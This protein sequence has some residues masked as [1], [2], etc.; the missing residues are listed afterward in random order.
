MTYD[1]ELVN[2][3]IDN[4]F[5]FNLPDAIYNLDACV[6]D[7]LHVTFKE[8]TGIYVIRNIV[9]GKLYVGSTKNIMK[10]ISEH[11]RLLDE[12]A[13]H[14]SKLQNA[15][16]KYSFK[17]FELRIYPINKD[18]EFLYDIEELLIH[19]YDSYAN[20][21]NMSEDSRCKSS[22]SEEEKLEIGNRMRQCNLG[23][24]CSEEHKRKVGLAKSIQNSG[25]GNPN[26]KLTKQDILFMRSN[27]SAYTCEEFHNMFDISKCTV[28]HIIHLRSWNYPDC[29]PEGYVLPKSMKK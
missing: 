9:D 11:L 24:K 22:W 8:V 5:M 3:W 21:Y 4:N 13:H 17:G 19:R 20:G 2:E 1:Y 28:R 6:R 7:R 29:I 26:S 23:K 16:N 12:D 15:I 14:S 25:S 10:R 18:R 27:A